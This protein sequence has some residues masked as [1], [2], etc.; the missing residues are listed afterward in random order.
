MILKSSK[1]IFA[2]IVS[3]MVKRSV[4][5][6]NV[7]DPRPSHASA[8]KLFTRNPLQE[9]PFGDLVHLLEEIDNDLY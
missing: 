8:I 6:E 3:G 4:P 5:L 9:E 2:G 1:A 7:Y